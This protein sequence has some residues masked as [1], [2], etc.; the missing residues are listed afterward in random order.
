MLAISRAMDLRQ[1]GLDFEANYM[2]PCHKTNC[3][4]RMLARHRSACLLIPALRWWICEF[5]VYTV[6]SKTLS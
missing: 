5:K 4:M 2:R 6:S 1:K 3:R